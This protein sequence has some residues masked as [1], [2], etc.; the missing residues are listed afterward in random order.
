MNPLTYNQF[1]DDVFMLLCRA[2]WPNAQIAQHPVIE[3]LIDRLNETREV[4]AGA[5]HPFGPENKIAA[6][7]GYFTIGDCKFQIKA[8]YSFSKFFGLVCDTEDGTHDPEQI[9]KFVAEVNDEAFTKP[10]ST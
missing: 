1:S 4:G 9:K 6:W 5:G 7:R 8:M 2:D 10:L 3:T